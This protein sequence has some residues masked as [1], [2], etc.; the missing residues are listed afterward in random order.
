MPP[1]IKITQKQIID[2][3]AEVVRTQGADGLNARNIA[4]AFGCST[5]PIFSNFRS[6]AQLKSA[7]VEEVTARYNC[8]MQDEI[9]RGEYPPYKASGMAYI[10]FAKEQREW[11]RLLFMRDRTGE[12]ADDGTK[13]LAPMTEM[14]QKSTG[15]T[16]DEAFLLHLEMWIFV[17]GI[18][19]MMVT[20]YQDWDRELIS[21][22][23][24][25]CYQ[26]LLQ[27]FLSQKKEQ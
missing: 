4:A 15:L 18:A 5:Q 16:K 25:D 6:M 27:R 21:R 26:G 2:A 11:F 19:T 3:A 12:Q 20:D 1:K 24:T 8:F 13:S 23:L 10:R 7:V 14:I 9:Q 17:H 22:M